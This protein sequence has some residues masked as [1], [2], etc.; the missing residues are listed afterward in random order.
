MSFS[1]GL[2]QAAPMQ[3]REAPA[4]LALRASVSTVSIASKRSFSRPVS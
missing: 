3:K 1:F 4:A 2:R